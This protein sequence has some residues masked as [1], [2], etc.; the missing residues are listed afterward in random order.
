MEEEF[1]NRKWKTR[2]TFRKTGEWA[3]VW[4][5]RNK[6]DTH[7]TELLWRRNRFLSQPLGYENCL[8][9]GLVTCFSCLLWEGRRVFLDFCCCHFG[10]LR[11]GFMLTNQGFNS[12]H[13]WIGS[14]TSPASTSRKMRLLAF[15]NISGC[16]F[17]ISQIDYITP[18][19][20]LSSLPLSRKCWLPVF[21]ECRKVDGC[22]WWTS[23]VKEVRGHG[24]ERKGVERLSDIVKILNL[25]YI[26]PH[27]V[28]ELEHVLGMQGPRPQRLVLRDKEPLRSGSH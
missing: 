26:S 4:V 17:L 14:Q 1:L 20:R 12:L 10:F 16:V 21:T 8:C 27:H 11:Q 25:C 18:S 28:G 19:P 6:P 9:Q 22:L 2:R 3:S 15:A 23:R 13:G 5:A 7:S 24:Q